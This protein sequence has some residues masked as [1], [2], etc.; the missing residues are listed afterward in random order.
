MDAFEILVV[1]LSITLAVFLISA[2]VLTVNLVKLTK[3]VQEITEKAEDIVDDAQKV[4]SFFSSSIPGALAGLVNNL[5]NTM[6][7]KKDKK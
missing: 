2:I 4:S 1:I 7:G 6:G 5:V 3:K